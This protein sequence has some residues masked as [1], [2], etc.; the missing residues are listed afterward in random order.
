[1]YKAAKEFVLFLG[2]KPLAYT[3]FYIAYDP[4]ELMRAA[5]N[6]SIK[7]EKV[8]KEIEEEIK[9]CRKIPD[10]L[11]T[12]SNNSRIQK[13]NYFSFSILT[14]IK[15]IKSKILQSI[16]FSSSLYFETHKYKK[17]KKV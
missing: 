9:N 10:P 5:L 1:M 14:I 17:F 2:E 12:H 8:K 7:F 15:I 11:P 16:N 3:L 4:R 6:F 13:L